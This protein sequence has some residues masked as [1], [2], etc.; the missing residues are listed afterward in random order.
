MSKKCIVLEDAVSVNQSGCAL[1]DVHVHL[2]EL[3]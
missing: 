1:S 3:E 2:K